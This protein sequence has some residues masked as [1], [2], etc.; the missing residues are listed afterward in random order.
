MYIVPL[1]CTRA[2]E[3][4]YEETRLCRSVE[5]ALVGAEGLHVAFE[6]LHVLIVLQAPVGG[7]EKV[8]GRGGDEAFE[9]DVGAQ[10]LH[11]TGDEVDILIDREEMEVVGPF[12]ILLSHA[13]APDELELMELDDVKGQRGDDGCGGEH[14]L[15]RLARKAEDEMAAREDAA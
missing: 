7:K 1:L 9:D 2:K 15:V 3:E 5:A 14:L 6:Q 10:A 8:L 13:G 11:E 12:G 4:E